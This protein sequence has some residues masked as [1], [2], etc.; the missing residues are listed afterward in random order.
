MSDSLQ[1]PMGYSPPGSSVHGISQTRILKWVA[2]SFSRKSSWPRDWTWVSQHCRQVLYH[3]SHQGSSANQLKM[4]GPKEEY[5]GKLLGFIFTKCIPDWILEKLAA[6]T[7]QWLQTEK[8]GP[9][10]NL[11]SLAKGPG[12]GQS[13]ETKT[14]KQLLLYFRQIS[15]KK[16]RGSTHTISHKGLVGSQDFHCFQAV[17]SHPKVLVRV[18]TEKTTRRAMT[19]ISA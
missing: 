9:R 7:H 1:P 16:N 8:K 18:V 17:M 4:L 3:L 10:K 11:L 19:W 15:Q 5:N 6:W 2:I 14:F 12:K 13:S